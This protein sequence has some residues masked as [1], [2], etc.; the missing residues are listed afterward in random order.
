[1]KSRQSRWNAV[2][3][4]LPNTVTAPR[5]EYRSLGAVD[6]NVFADEAAAEAAARN[7]FATWVQQC[8]AA[9]E[10][11]HRLIREVKLERQF[12]VRVES[13][14]GLRT[15]SWHEAPHDGARQ[16]PAAPPAQPLEL[17]S[18]TIDQLRLAS[19]HRCRCGPCAGNGMV[20]C[21]QCGGS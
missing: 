8:D 7:A 17:W 10:D 21:T 2:A 1:M 6:P 18:T 9:P 20:V 12:W 13:E 5:D 11:P 15:A 4:A 3:S 14:L 16:L 19:L